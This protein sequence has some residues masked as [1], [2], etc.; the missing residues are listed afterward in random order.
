MKREGA[1]TIL[2]SGGFTAFADPVALEIGFD[3]AFA[4]RLEIVDG[5][6]SGVAAPPILG[7]EAKRRALAAALAERKLDAA[8]SL[9]IGDGANDIP[10]L[11][12]AGLGV[13]YHAKPAAAA[14]AAARIEH[15]DLTALLYAQGYARS[16]WETD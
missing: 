8:A 3:R 1:L 12:A 10:M 4:N 9:A 6:L 14:A 16:E 2:V 5:K 13:A 15:G 11:R 7:A